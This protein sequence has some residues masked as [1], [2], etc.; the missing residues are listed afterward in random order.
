MSIHIGSV[1]LSQN[2][3][4]VFTI[5]STKSN[6]MKLTSPGNHVFMDIGD[7]NFGQRLSNEPFVFSYKNNNG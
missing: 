6:V 5:Y 4:D 3:T 7:Y 2:S 1:P